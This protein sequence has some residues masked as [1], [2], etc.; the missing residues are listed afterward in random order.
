MK[1]LKAIPE[2]KVVML[3]AFLA[4]SLIMSPVFSHADESPGDDTGSEAPVSG[5]MPQ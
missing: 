5:D 4:A 1:M 3:F 2:L